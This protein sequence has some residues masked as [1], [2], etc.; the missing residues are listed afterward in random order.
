V[1]AK[2]PGCPL[3]EG[4]GTSAEETKDQ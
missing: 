1:T 3:C 4:S 2:K